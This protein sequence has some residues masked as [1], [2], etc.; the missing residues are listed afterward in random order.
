MLEVLEPVEEPELV[1]RLK[2]PMVPR[3]VE[4]G[5]SAVCHGSWGWDAILEVV[6]PVQ[7]EAAVVVLEPE[8]V[9]W[10]R[11]LGDEPPWW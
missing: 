1:T 11:R 6:A 2:E 8:G 3:A 4:V 9:G 10:P 5:R 7:E